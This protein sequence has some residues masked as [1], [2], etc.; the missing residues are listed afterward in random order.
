MVRALFMLKQFKTVKYKA[1]AKA[2]EGHYNDP[3]SDNKV[4]RFADVIKVALSPQCFRLC[5]PWLEPV[6]F[7]L[8]H[9]PA[10]KHLCSCKEASFTFAFT[11][12]HE[13]L[14]TC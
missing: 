6:V 14:A 2:L 7:R 4:K 12:L 11:L 9:P 8:V 5:P 1:V 13:I 3:N 10:L